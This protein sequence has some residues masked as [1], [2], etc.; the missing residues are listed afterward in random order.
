MQAAAKIHII[1]DYSHFWANKQ[2]HLD[3]MATVEEDAY[4]ARRRTMQ[5]FT[6]LVS[7]AQV[8]SSLLLKELLECN[9]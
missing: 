2:I 4:S 9:N 3:Q 5:H 7:I 8:W 1:H 6:P